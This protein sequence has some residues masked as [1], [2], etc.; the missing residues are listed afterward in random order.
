[1]SNDK[2]MN[3]ISGEHVEVDGLYETEKGRSEV[4]CRGEVFP[5]DPQLGTT[6]WT[7]V[8]FRETDHHHDGRTD[9]RLVP[10]KDTRGG[11]M[12]R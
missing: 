7:L 5:A 12:R 9:P 3:P 2:D 1:M 4:L 8:E 10:K 11:F 6:E